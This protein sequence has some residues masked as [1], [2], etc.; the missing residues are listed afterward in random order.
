MRIILSDRLRGSGEVMWT[1]WRL[2]RG[3]GFCT[4]KREKRGSGREGVR[5]GEGGR[6]GRRG[7]YKCRY[8]SLIPRLS[9]PL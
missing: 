6:E 3:I 8:S 9:P 7:R 5:K 1:A 2:L 4:D